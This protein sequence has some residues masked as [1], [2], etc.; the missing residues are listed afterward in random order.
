MEE[1]EEVNVESPQPAD[2][3]NPTSEKEW[4]V[5]AQRR[6]NISDTQVKIGY[7]SGSYKSISPDTLFLREK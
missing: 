4:Y 3:L 2:P 1:M 5:Y 6:R 7:H